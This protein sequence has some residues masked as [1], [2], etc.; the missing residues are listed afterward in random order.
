MLLG[1]RTFSVLLEGLGPCYFKVIGSSVE[2]YMEVNQKS[3]LSLRIKTFPIL[4]QIEGVRSAASTATL[5][6][7]IFTFRCQLEGNG[8]N[9]LACSP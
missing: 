3:I 5:L 7:A 1:V 8:A 2:L 4:D 9:H 6:P